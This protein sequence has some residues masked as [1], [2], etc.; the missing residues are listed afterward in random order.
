MANHKSAA[1]R[2]RGSLRKNAVNTKRKNSTRT[3]EKNLM[4]AIAEKKIKD[5][6]ALLSTYVSQMAKSA[7]KGVFKRETASRKIG[8][9]TARVQQA[10][11]SK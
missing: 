7:Q 9:L 11:S 4:K 8:R 1:K 5:I 2:A 6:P 10:L 3:H